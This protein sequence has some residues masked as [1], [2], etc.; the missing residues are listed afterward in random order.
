MILKGIKHD[1]REIVISIEN[2]SDQDALFVEVAAV[3]SK[4]GSPCIQ[5]WSKPFTLHRIAAKGNCAVPLEFLDFTDG[6]D[7]CPH[8]IKGANMEVAWRTGGKE[9]FGSVPLSDCVNG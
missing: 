3:I 4:V 6:P 2:P 9:Y 1:S 7:F 5:Y 8:D